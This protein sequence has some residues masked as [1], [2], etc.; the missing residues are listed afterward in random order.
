MEPRHVLVAG[1]WHGDTGWAIGVVEMLPRFLPEEKDRLILQ[2][3][4]FGISGRPS[5]Q[6][7]LHQLNKQL[8]K[9]DADVVFIDG[10]HE[11]HPLLRT[12]KKADGP[13][14]PTGA[15]KLRRVRSRIWWAP[16][17]FR[18]RWHGHEWVAVGGA[19]SVDRA[20]RE[21]GVSWFAEE[22]LT[23]AEIEAIIDAG[24]ADVVISHDRPAQAPLALPPWPD[25][26][27]LADLARSEAHRDRIQR[28]V[29]G[30]QPRL[31]MHGHYHVYS[32][33]FA[34]MPFGQLELL[35]LDMNR[36]AGSL[37]RVNVVD[38]RLEPP[39]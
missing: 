36:R 6:S 24:P 26:W 13:L 28:V 8:E 35:A 38:L 21:P 3:G 14:I 33:D 39:R 19:V 29:D 34:G 4:D 23:E 9:A 25:E 20:L 2:L 37:M 22:E 18:W 27:D 11:D 7:Y 17:G 31:Q 30:I 32:H 15:T 10:N 16:R 5:G 12:A 1:D